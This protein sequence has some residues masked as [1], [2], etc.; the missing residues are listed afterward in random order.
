MF[1]IQLIQNMMMILGEKNSG[2]NQKIE[3][4]MMKGMREKLAAYLLSEYRKNKALTF[5]ILPNRNELAEFLNVSRPS[6]SRELARMKS[7]GLI[8]YYQNTFKL[9]NMEKLSACLLNKE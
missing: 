8:D 7:E 4:L 5:Q 9:V 3:L 1:L 2:L 6:M